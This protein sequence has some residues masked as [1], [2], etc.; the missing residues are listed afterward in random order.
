[1]SQSMNVIKNVQLKNEVFILSN[2]NL[3]LTTCYGKKNS[4]VISYIHI[5]S[6]RTNG[7]FLPFPWNHRFTIS[8]NYLTHSKSKFD[9]H[10]T[11][12]PLGFFFFLLHLDQKKVSHASPLKKLTNAWTVCVITHP[13]LISSF[14]VHIMKV[15]YVW[16][17]QQWSEVFLQLPHVTN[18]VL[19][20]KKKKCSNIISLDKRV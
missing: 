20:L 17:S 5:D 10:H 14:N 2:C 3:I 18:D 7:W 12:N 4:K 8:L 1:M 16:K 9:A 15:S 6:W 13:S 11:L 19:H